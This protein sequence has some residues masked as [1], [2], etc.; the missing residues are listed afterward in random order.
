MKPEPQLRRLYQLVADGLTDLDDVLKEQI[1]RLKADCS[2]ARS[3]WRGSQSSRL[4]RDKIA[5]FGQ[6]MRTNITQGEA[7][8]RKAYLRSLIGAVEVDD[9]VVRIHGSKTVLERAV[10]AD[11]ATHPGVRGFVR[12]W[13]AQGESNPCFRR[14]RATS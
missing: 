7:P 9:H 12:K 4:D 14:E 6:L 13:R 8:F 1:V 10:L 11:Q 2:R 3:A 5:R